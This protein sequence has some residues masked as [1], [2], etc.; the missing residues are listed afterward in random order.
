MKL[1][2]ATNLSLDSLSER[3]RRTLLIGGV[4]A[5]L[6]LLYVVI[7]LDSSV[8]SAHKRILKKQTDLAWM[9]TAAPE[10]AA[11]GGTHVGVNGQSLLVLVDSS[12]RESG[13]ASAL[14]GSDPAGPG[15]LS[16]RFQKAPFDTLIPW[17]ARLSQQNGI[18]VDTAS[19]ESAGSPGLVNA[20]LVLHTD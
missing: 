3:D 15:G 1:P 18:R 11:T 12:A 20:A 5:A 6:L 14:A 10:L 13:L 2:F 8:S 16:V 19:I 7:Q 17:L 4:I 9:R